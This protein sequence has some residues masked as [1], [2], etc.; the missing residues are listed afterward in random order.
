MRS[1]EGHFEIRISE[2]FLAKFLTTVRKPRSWT[3][4]WYRNCHLKSLWQ[5]SECRSEPFFHSDLNV[6]RP[7]KKVPRKKISEIHGKWSFNENSLE[8]NFSQKRRRKQ[9]HKSCLCNSLI[10]S[11][12]AVE[13]THYSKSQIYVQKFSLTSF[14]PKFFLTIFL[15]KSKLSTAKKPKTTTFS[16]VFHPKKSTI[17][18]GKSKLDFCTKKYE[19]F[20]Q[21]VYVGPNLGGNEAFG[22]SWR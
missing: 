8:T 18:L 3:I 6:R 16:R 10:F 11:N 15:V 5:F 12:F 2:T 7:R 1:K 19:D 17:L 22:K 21:C 4:V 14:S 13:N 9:S 20:E